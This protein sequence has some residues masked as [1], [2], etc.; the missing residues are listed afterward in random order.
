M[1]AKFQVTAAED[2]LVIWP[3]QTE[4]QLDRDGTYFDP[5]CRSRGD[6]CGYDMHLILA[7]LV[8]ASR[9]LKDGV[10]EIEVD[11]INFKPK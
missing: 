4:L 2:G 7:E 5:D 9:G 6:V 8:D 3:A 1:K 10:Y 11:L